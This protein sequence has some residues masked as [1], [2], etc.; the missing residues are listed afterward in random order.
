[1]TFL[2]IV[3]REL[4]VA[5]RRRATLWTRTL[6]ALG[7]VATAVCFYLANLDV[8]EQQLSRKIFLGLVWVALIYALVSGRRFTAD[9]LSEEKREGTLGLLFLTDLKGYDVVLGKLA[10]TSLNG[11]Y[12]LLGVLPVL[13]APLL[14]GGISNGEFWRMVLVLVNTFMASLAIGIFV[15]ALSRQAP[16][17][18]G[19]NLGL[20]LLVFAVPAAC[21]I[22]VVACL[23]AH[24]YLPAFVASWWTGIP[25]NSPKLWP[26]VASAP[27]YLPP[28]FYSCPIFSLLAGSDTLYRFQ[29]WHFWGSIITLQGL[30]WLLLGL[31]SRIV[32][33][34]WQD[35]VPSVKRAGRRE[36]WRSLNYGPRATRAAFRQKLLEVNAFYWLAARARLRPVHVWCLLAA[37]AG[38]WLWI[39]QA[40]GWEWQPRDA[41]RPANVVAAFL[42]NFTL[43][44]WI[45]IEAGRRLAEEHKMGTFELVLSTALN[46]RDIVRGQWLALR[47]QFLFPTLVVLGVECVLLVTNLDWGSPESTEGLVVWVAGMV[48]LVVD[49]VAVSWVAMDCA[50]VARNP[51]MAT[52]SA[53]MRIFVIPLVA[54]A[55]IVGALASYTAMLNRPEFTWRAYLGWWFF[56]G[57]AADA[58]FGG[59]AWRRL[60]TRFRQLASERFTS[61]L[62]AAP[63]SADAPSAPW[64][65]ALRIADTASTGPPNT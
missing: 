2:P 61:G 54:F 48:M 58:G 4:R 9:C 64:P 42:F 13:A 45:A 50:L 20:V 33:H 11:F 21:G 6:V 55:V 22:V 31:A 47:R 56:L 52:V 44:M 37:V 12:G 39:R 5:A 1:M 65:D 46:E 15:S 40:F 24:P 17:A 29:A 59:L 34:S 30:T 19:A 38:Y 49:M 27:W 7:A 35:R 8:P 28:L 62:A 63:P 60:H 14:I 32:P 16:R 18:M 53:I 41:L 43:K 10:A 3:A 36:F 51:G 57:I 26:M 25:M 23:R